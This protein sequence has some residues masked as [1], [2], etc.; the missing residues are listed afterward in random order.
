MAESDLET[1]TSRLPT[2]TR[3]PGEAGSIGPH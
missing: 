3:D 2:V 1:S